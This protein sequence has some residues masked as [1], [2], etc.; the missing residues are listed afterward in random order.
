MQNIV[1]NPFHHLTLN[2]V[3]VCVCVCVCVYIYIYTHTHT[4]LSKGSNYAINTSF[5]LIALSEA[6]CSVSTGVLPWR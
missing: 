1:K 4:C 6:V 5:K 2:G 3:C